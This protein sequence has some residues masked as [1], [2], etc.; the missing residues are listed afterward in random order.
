M[1]I[2]L[3]SKTN[4]QTIFCLFIKVCHI[5][6]KYFNSL[7]LKILP[8]T[9]LGGTTDRT[10]I[11]G[12]DGAFYNALKQLTVENLVLFTVGQYLRAEIC[13]TFC[14]LVLLLIQWLITHRIP[15]PSVNLSLHRSCCKVK[16][17]HWSQE[18]RAL[19]SCHRL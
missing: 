19:C 17:R 1:V 15:S 3:R 6:K 4:K 14:I 10:L 18:I 7:F 12:E 13:C 8:H 9:S 16:S 11:R 2:F 5:L